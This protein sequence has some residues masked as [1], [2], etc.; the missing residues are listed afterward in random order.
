MR[1]P[2]LF[3]CV[4]V[5]YTL[6][7]FA[8]IGAIDSIHKIFLFGIDV[9]NFDLITITNLLT[10]VI[11]ICAFVAAIFR[12]KW[13]AWFVMITTGLVAI[14]ALIMLIATIVLIVKT[15]DFEAFK[16]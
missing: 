12:S 13:C 8:L 1:D 4:S 7:A 3:G 6:M 9:T 5:R 11:W 10:L 16:G 2:R 14:I 15:Y